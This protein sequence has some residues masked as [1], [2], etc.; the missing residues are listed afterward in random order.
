MEQT[1]AT[2]AGGGSE[3]NGKELCLLS[4]DG[5]GV[6]GLSSLL[7]LQKLM[8]SLDPDNPPLPCDYFDMIGGTSTG[9][10][11]AIMLGRLHMTV[12]ECITEYKRLS[13]RIFTKVHHRVSWGGELR[14]RFDH[15]ALEEGIRSLLGRRGLDPDELFAEKPHTA[16]CKT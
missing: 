12:D 10:L 16:R 7:I 9:G 11:I 6:R 8:E 5:G 4:L 1:M 15:E 2:S 13:P 3:T 14:G